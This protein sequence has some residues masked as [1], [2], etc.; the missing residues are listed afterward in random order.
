LQL[1]PWLDCVFMAPH[2]VNLAT[3]GSQAHRRSVKSHLAFDALPV[4]D[5]VKYIHTARDG[6]D[7]CLSMQNHEIGAAN[8]IESGMA[9]GEPPPIPPG[10]GPPREI[11]RDPRAYFLQ[12]MDDAEAV[13]PKVETGAPFCEFEQTYWDERARSNL[14]MVHYA[15]LK[16]DLGG[17]MARIAAFLEIDTP[18]PL[19]AQLVEA[20]RFESMQAQGDAILPGIGQFFDNGPQRFLHKGENGRWRGVLTDEDLARYDRLEQ[21]RMSPGLRA[22]INGGR[23]AVGGDPRRAAD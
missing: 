4:F 1:A 22:W 11:P 7:A 15:D 9:A 17:E 21:A 6:R 18:A 20:A 19:M 12:W 5:S 14:L 13:A 23:G 8:R 10:D 16:A 2:D 3:L